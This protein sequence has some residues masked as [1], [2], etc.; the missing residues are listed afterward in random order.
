MRK[1]ERLGAMPEHRPPDYNIMTP[2]KKGENRSFWYK[3][4]VAWEVDRNGRE[5]ISCNID[6]PP[7]N[8]RIIIVANESK[9]EDT[10]SELGGMYTSDLPF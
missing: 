1:S 4:G 7:Q 5:F 8:G 2:V 9:E 6:L 3:I 10:D